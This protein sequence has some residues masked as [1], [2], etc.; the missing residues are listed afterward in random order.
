MRWLRRLFVFLAILGLTA[1]GYAWRAGIEFGPRP[2]SSLMQVEIGSDIKFVE[3]N[4][5]RFA[6]IEEGQ[7]PLILLFHGY[8]ETARS[9]KIVQHR[10]ATAGYRVVAPYMRGYPPTAFAHDYSVPAL[11]QDIVSLIDALG[12]KSAIVIGH[13]WGASAAYAAAANAPEKI[14]KL[15]AIA[16]PHARAF[17]G[18]P[19]IFLDAPHFLYYQL[20]WAE[21]LVWSND[22]AH[23]KRLYREWAPSY[24]PPH[25]VLADIKATLRTPGAT[26]ST[27]DYYWTVFR[28]DPKVAQASAAKSIVVPTLVIAGAEDGPVDQAQYEKARGAFAGVYTYVEL[29]GVGHFPQLEAPDRTAD[30][31]V[32]FI[33]APH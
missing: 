15:V 30:V 28:T 1:A 4:A 20:P 5:I 16:L 7:G 8:P 12:A 6:Y 22:F 23:I 19:S 24:D 10:L 17:V 3:A 18:D 32:S 2:P 33:G 27:L 26:Q 21:R 25:E 31:I 29:K 9:W 11:G 13:D 14:T